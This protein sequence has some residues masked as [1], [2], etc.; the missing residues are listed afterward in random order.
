MM[1]GVDKQA[2]AGSEIV[3]E[4]ELDAA[5]FE[6]DDDASGMISFKEFFRW[7][8]VKQDREMEAKHCWTI[9]DVSNVDL[10]Q[11]DSP[12]GRSGAIRSTQGDSAVAEVGTSG[13]HAGTTQPSTN[14]RKARRA[15]VVAMAAEEL[16][17]EHVAWAQSSAVKTDEAREAKRA[18]TRQKRERR[19]AKWKQRR[20]R[21][22]RRL[23][24]MLCAT[25]DRKN[26]VQKRRKEGGQ[27]TDGRMECRKL[28]NQID[29]D[30]SGLLDLD[31]IAKLAALLGVKLTPEQQEAAMQE[32]DGDGSGEVDFDEFWQWWV[33]SGGANDTKTKKHETTV[34][35]QA[36]VKWAKQ[37][38]LQVSA[39]QQ[40]KRSR[41]L[42]NV[43]NRRGMTVEDMK[44][45]SA[46]QKEVHSSSVWLKTDQK[47]GM[48]MWGRKTAGPVGSLGNWE[49]AI[50][51]RS[52][53]W[54][55]MSLWMRESDH[56]F[57][58]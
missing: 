42:K 23:N 54:Q 48:T 5:M 43:A 55:T 14:R 10:E 29:S 28:F 2:S 26:A 6:M 40:Q 1:P 39:T 30:G 33:A 44:K 37:T 16:E 56:D 4:A 34:L 41:D 15:S 7:W 25:S 19:R 46:G 47:S 57:V 50:E 18:V 49:T 27:H 52:K 36:S 3:S 20:A 38:H 22:A 53:Q 58:E 51:T 13:K 45:I 21:C 11:L 9:T 12:R 8:R 35:G 17:K 31:E 32:M 24:C